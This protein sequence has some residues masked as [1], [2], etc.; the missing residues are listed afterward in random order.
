MGFSYSKSVSIGP[1]R[2]NVGE[3][4]VGCLD[5]GVLQRKALQ[6]IRGFWPIPDSTTPFGETSFV[7]ETRCGHA[8]A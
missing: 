6:H 3:S 4:G 5:W 2:F 7:E 1:L 8:F